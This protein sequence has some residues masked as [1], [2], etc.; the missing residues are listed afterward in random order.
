MDRD[1]NQIV[2][3]FDIEENVK[4]FKVKFQASYLLNLLSIIKQDVTISATTNKHMY[5]KVENDAY[6][7]EYLLAPIEIKDK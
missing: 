2:A 4:E 3:G 6:V 1:D 7:V 5:I